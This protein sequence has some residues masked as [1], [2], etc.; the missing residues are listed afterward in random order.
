MLSFDRSDGHFHVR[1]VAICVR[2]DTVLIHQ[3]VGDTVWSLPGGRV[4]MGE[5]SAPALVREMAE[6]LQTRVVNLTLRAV[7]EVIDRRAQGG[8]FHEVGFYYAVDLPDVP[9][10]TTPFRGPERANPV[11]FWWCPTHQLS[12]IVLLPVP[13][14]SVIHATQVQHLVY[15]YDA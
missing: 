10:Q 3:A 12:T 4:E 7:I 14:R 9:W 5:S 8:Y 11:D 2:H 1:T 15:H 6:E 13:V